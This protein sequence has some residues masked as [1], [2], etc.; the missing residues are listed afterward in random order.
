M[1]LKKLAQLLCCLK[2]RPRI[3]LLLAALLLLAL[4]C[5]RRWLE[6]LLVLYLAILAL[7]GLIG[8]IRLLQGILRRWCWKGAAAPKG[9]GSEGYP[10][11][12]DVHVPPHT[13]KRP[14]PMIYS[15][16]YLMAQGLA[17]TWDNPDIQLYDGA[18]PVSSHALAPGRAYTIRARIWNGSVDAPAVNVLVRFSYLT[19][20]AGTVKHFIGQT[21]VDVPVKGAAGL[22]ALAEQVWITPPTPG[23]YCLQVELAWPDDANPNNNL[24]QENVD[25]K[26]LNSPRATFTFTLRNDSAFRR[27]IRLVADGYRVPPRDPCAER[28]PAGGEPGRPQERDPYA[29]HRPGAN[30]VP[31]GWQVAYLPGNAIELGPGEEQIVTIDVTAPDGF[32]G[33]QAINVNA[34][35]GATLVGGVTV[36]AQ[37]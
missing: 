27:R 8:L 35:D 37:S 15:Q 34:L 3:L 11:S 1:A 24:G 31:P 36:Y 16:Y 32:V 4:Y 2:E 22:P 21:L 6:S 33:R 28:P 7:L 5:L 17:V 26:P 19:F 14:D 20:G 9:A 30:P 12:R 13:Y 25:V 23:H 29:R 10:P 18:M